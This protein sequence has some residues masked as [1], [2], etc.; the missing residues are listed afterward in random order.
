MLYQGGI[1]S[2]AQTRAPIRGCWAGRGLN[3]VV[4]GE[5]VWTPAAQVFGLGPWLAPFMKTE[6]RSCVELSTTQIGWV[7]K[8]MAPGLPAV[9]AASAGIV[10]PSFENWS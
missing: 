8:H 2:S 4:P 3:R 9:T 10:W 1:P 5:R 6:T 7:M